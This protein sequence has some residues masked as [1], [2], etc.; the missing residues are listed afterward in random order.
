MEWILVDVCHVFDRIQWREEVDEYPRDGRLL[1]II[2]CSSDVYVVDADFCEG[3]VIYWCSHPVQVILDWINEQLKV[4]Y[5][6]IKGKAEPYKWQELFTKINLSSVAPV[7]AV[8]GVIGRLFGVPGIPQLEMDTNGHLMILPVLR[9]SVL[10]DLFA[11]KV[12][13]PVKT[14]QGEE[15]RPIP[16]KTAT[17]E[18]VML[19]KPSQEG[20]PGQSCR[21]EIWVKGRG[22]LRG[23]TFLPY[24]PS[25]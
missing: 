10:Q 11:K 13:I 7:S 24:A 3:T 6:L 2:I 17:P 12:P 8:L 22:R 15:G 21:P 9:R 23:V 4:M 5:R 19:N 14:S 16:R 18:A 25:H 1:W 20:K